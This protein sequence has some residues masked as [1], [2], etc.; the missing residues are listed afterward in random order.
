[1]ANNISISICST[2]IQFASFLDG[3]CKLKPLNRILQ[4][5]LAYFLLLNPFSE[6]NAQ[7]TVLSSILNPPYQKLLET[8]NFVCTYM[9]ELKIFEEQDTQKIVWTNFVKQVGTSNYTCRKESDFLTY[10][11]HQSGNFNYGKKKNI[12]VWNILPDSVKAVTICYSP[13]F[14]EKLN[15]I[16]MEKLISVD[17]LSDAAYFII[18][19]ERNSDSSDV[20][21]KFTRL[22]LNK[23]TDRIDKYEYRATYKEM[24]FFNRFTLTRFQSNIQHIDDS[25]RLDTQQ[26]RIVKRIDSR[27][28]DAINMQKFEST[29]KIKNTIAPDFTLKT[30]AGLK[31]NLRKQKK[32]IVLLDFFYTTCAP[33]MLMHDTLVD[34]QSKLGTKDFQII[35][36]DPQDKDIKKVM[37]Y[38][39][40]K[41]IKYPV[42]IC[43]EGIRDAYQVS[44]YPSIF[45]LDR[46][47]L[48][49]GVFVGYTADNIQR[50]KELISSILAE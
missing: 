16:M 48:V 27:N 23:N 12:L 26:L 2:P 36:L 29:L 32:K 43:N 6:L 17:S 34:M 50:M 15:S 40:D 1:M 39:Q 7:Q 47:Q 38:C 49:R 35:G 20:K 28:R 42:A 37:A 21:Q 4:S 19:T 24:H 44:I 5:I 11:Q 33:C 45:V 31:L 30:T 3:N 9:E 25:I 18:T 8:Q 14:K 13:L 22:W 41:Q 10:V 46:E